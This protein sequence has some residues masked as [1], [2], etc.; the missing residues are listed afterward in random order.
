MIYQTSWGKEK[1]HGR[2]RGRVNRGTICINFT[3]NLFSGKKFKPCKIEVSGKSRYSKSRHSLRVNNTFDIDR[4]DINNIL[5]VNG[6]INKSLTHFHDIT[7]MFDVTRGDRLRYWLSVIFIVVTRNTSPH[8]EHWRFSVGYKFE[9]KLITS[10]L[11]LYM[12]NSKLI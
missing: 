3:K 7:T 9:N 11:W 5:N 1:S 4:Y 6:E 10:Q 12:I 2:L 8:L